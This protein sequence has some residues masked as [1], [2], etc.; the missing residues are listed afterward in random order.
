MSVDLAK[1]NPYVAIASKKHRNLKKKMEKIVKIEQQLASGKALD[2]EQLALLNSKKSVE[3]ALAD[4]AALK[5][6]LEEV[7]KQ[8]LE[9]QQGKVSAAPE[10]TEE[11]EEKVE[12]QETEEPVVE[13]QEN[14]VN[15]T[16]VAETNTELDFQLRVVQ[17]AVSTMTE[18]DAETVKANEAK[19]RQEFEDKISKLLKALHVYQRY[20]D[21]TT[22]NLPDTVD[23]FGRTLLGLTTISGFQDTLN[24]SNKVATYYLNDDL[25][26][27]NDVVRGCNYVQMSQLI[28]NLADEMEKIPPNRGGAGALTA[29]LRNSISTPA[30]HPSEPTIN[31]PPVP[32]IPPATDVPVVGEVSPSKFDLPAPQPVP[33]FVPLEPPSFGT[34]QFGAVTTTT[35][36]PTLVPSSVPSAAS[37]LYATINFQPEPFFQL[38]PPSISVAVAPQSVIAPVVHE[39]VLLSE[40]VFVE[41]AVQPV[42]VA[43][44]PELTNVTATE[45]SETVGDDANAVAEQSKSE[46]EE[47]TN[48]ANANKKSPRTRPNQRPKRT[49]NKEGENTEGQQRRRN[50]DRFRGAKKEGE[51]NEESGAV[52]GNKGGF[53]KKRSFN[54]EKNE[55]REHH[56]ENKEG[57]K[58][59]NWAKK[60]NKRAENKDG[61]RKEATAEAV[62]TSEPAAQPVVTESAPVATSSSEPVVSEPVSKPNEAIEA[63]KAEAPVKRSSYLDAVRP[64]AASEPKTEESKPAHHS[65]PYRENNNGGKREEG[66]RPRRDRS[67][68]RAPREGGDQ[69]RGDRPQGNRFSGDRQPR[70][71]GENN[72]ERRPFRTNNNNNKQG[73]NN[74][75]NSNSN[76][77]TV[78]NTQSVRRPAP[79]TK[80]E[81]A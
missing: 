30:M 77:R 81:S 39:P 62:E 38:A 55:N 25:A 33:Q 71:D 61:P 47:N 73:G 60:F 75:N 31:V 34:L 29:F 8:Q 52:E 64:G 2:Q 70:G 15:D 18:P 72:G 42:A 44:E 37:P 20:K 17:Y 67:N 10:T 14:V 76:S 23:F 1:E 46:G 32:H 54:R 11:V 78:N 56:N 41:S 59:Y 49:N 45:S 9:E 27:Q 79:S 35:T 58:D 36:A 21:V 26:V 43:E 57:G 51:G 19:K 12:V 4:V 22:R 80:T 3:K 53:Q 48:E 28:D 66:D 63:P 6:Q 50:N 24:H 40:P 16:V 74:N 65:K 13:E 7:A 69:P 68:N 5:A